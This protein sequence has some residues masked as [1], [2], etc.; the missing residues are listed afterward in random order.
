MEVGFGGW[1]YKAAVV[2]GVGSPNCVV[3]SYTVDKFVLTAFDSN[4]ALLNYYAAQDTACNGKP[5][6]SPVW[7][8]SLHV[9]RGGRWMNALYQ[10]TQAIRPAQ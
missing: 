9:K 1:T 5:V 6:P 8:S 7:V 10:Q 4:T 2:A 3:R